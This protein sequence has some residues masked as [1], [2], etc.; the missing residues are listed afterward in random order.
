MPRTNRSDCSPDFTISGDGSLEA[1]RQG[2]FLFGTRI[3]RQEAISLPSL[4]AVVRLISEESAD[5]LMSGSLRVV[6]RDKEEVDLPRFRKAINLMQRPNNFNSGRSFLQD[7]FA[8]FLLDGNA[9][10]YIDRDNFGDPF[11]LL[12]CVPEDCRIEQVGADQVYRLRLAIGELPGFVRVQPSR[13]VV[14]SLWP[15]MEGGEYSRAWRPGMGT[16]PLRAIE[17]TLQIAIAIEHQLRESL[18]KGMSLAGKTVFEYPVGQKV[19]EAQVR[20]ISQGVRQKGRDPSAVYVLDKGA[21]VKLLES[22]PIGEQAQGLR[23]FQVKEIFRA[24]GL[25]ETLGG[26]EISSWGQGISQL[27]KLYEMYC[28]RLHLR[29]FLEGFSQTY[30]ERPQQSGDELS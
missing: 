15:R 12:R 27:Q 30:A 3:R 9:L 19:D 26:V 6:D 22:A 2:L 11:R 13:N 4:M 5:K 21:Q 20:A 24:Y 18:A 28:A 8:D 16:S 1:A 25:P 17:N 29:T 10:C 23:E 7:M 14:H